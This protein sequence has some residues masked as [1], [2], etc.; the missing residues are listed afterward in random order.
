[1][2]TSD[3]TYK[4]AGQLSEA[5]MARKVSAVELARE[6]IGR[7]EACEPKINAVCVRDFTAAAE[8]ARRADARLAAGERGPL[9]GV[10]MTIKESF[11]LA[12]TP[13]TWGLLEHR[14][15]VAAEDALAVQRLKAA[16]AV[17]LGK[18]NV[19]VALA[20]WQSYNDIYGVTNN[21]HD[22]SRSPGGSSG[23]SSA[24]LAVGYGALSIGSDIGGSLRVPAHFCGIFAHK[25]TF[26]LA[27]PRGHSF[28]GA[29]PLPGSIDLSVIGPMARS[30]GDLEVLLEAIVAPDDL[31]DGVGYRL[32]LPPARHARLADFRV[33][34]LD[35]HP[36]TATEACVRSA[37][38]ELA[39]GLEKAGAAVVRASELLPDMTSGARLYMR[40][41]MATLAAR[42]PAEAQQRLRTA[43]AALDPSDASLGA[44]R[45]R[46]A[47]A[48]FR[49]WTA[50]N[51]RRIG[52][53]ARWRALFATFDAVICPVTPTPAFPHDHSPDQEKRRLMI[54]GEPHAYLDSLLWPGVATLPGLPA[55]ALPIGRSPEGLP[56]G[57][58][59][60]GPWLEDRTPLQLARL[61]EREF[62][63]FG[64]PKA[65]AA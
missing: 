62:G 59:I 51:A 45:L 26:A 12:G 37:I 40:L 47:A 46:G 11:N 21:P 22:L 6:A 36:L 24:A 8:A 39:S 33:L 29:P 52:A 32:E 58:Q 16:G 55:T 41:L 14:N 48:S 3:W 60:I 65:F 53:R 7:I 61:I 10:P 49:E 38:G 15:F 13:T 43:A 42:F 27:P 23:G 17:I 18:T 64:P 54:N 2:R 9:L 44:E 4:T 31:E 56:I 25:P 5:L 19:P 63:G 50:D 30:A 20:D 1:M 35:A 28:P 57:A 34:A